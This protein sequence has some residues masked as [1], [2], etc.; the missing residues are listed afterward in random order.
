M[1]LERD[2]AMLLDFDPEVVGLASQPFTLRWSGR[3]SVAHTPDYFARRGD[4]GAVV[5]D[6][7]PRDRVPGRW[8]WGQ[9]APLIPA[10]DLAGW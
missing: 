9:Y 6:V 8:L 2:H 7:R 1:W 5:V 3:R 4:G 10:V